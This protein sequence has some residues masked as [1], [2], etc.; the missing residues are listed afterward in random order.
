MEGGGAY[1]GSTKILTMGFLRKLW[2]FLKLALAF[3]AIPSLPPIINIEYFFFFV[4][5]YIT[6]EPNQNLIF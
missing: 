6:L 1:T 4:Q 5:L 3:S 2:I